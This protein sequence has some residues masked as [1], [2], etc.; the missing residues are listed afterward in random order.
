MSPARTSLLLSGP[1]SLFCVF[2]IHLRLMDIILYISLFICLYLTF[3]FDCQLQEA[4]DLSI[5]LIWWLEQCLALSKG[6]IDICRMNE[7]INKH[8][9]T[10]KWIFWGVLQGSDNFGIHSPS[11]LLSTGGG[12]IFVMVI[13]FI[14]LND[15]DFKW[16][17][18]SVIT[19]L[20][21]IATAVAEAPT[22]I[23]LLIFVSMILNIWAVK[24]I[25]MISSVRFYILKMYL[26]HIY[27]YVSHSWKVFR[28]LKHIVEKNGPFVSIMV[29]PSFF[30]RWGRVVFGTRDRKNWGQ[31]LGPLRGK[32]SSQ[33]RQQ[34]LRK[35]CVNTAF[36][37]PLRLPF[38]F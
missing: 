10:Q 4:M 34:G 13:A 18:Y 20:R 38:L 27:D 24:F 5:L 30:W 17:S 6:K 16:L 14:S 22:A 12:H 29:G 25:T 33:A 36:P 26:D 1:S 28:T 3:P 11:A 9:W 21:F 37:F 32:K 19:E 8:E 7:W 15:S 2:L 23:G 31:Q 35:S